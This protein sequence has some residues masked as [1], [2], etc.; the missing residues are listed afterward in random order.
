MDQLVN[1]VRRL[2]VLEATATEI[3]AATKNP[4][5]AISCDI[6]SPEA[7]AEALD[8]VGQFLADFPVYGKK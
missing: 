2:P 5:L 4:V 3:S 8:K 1:L 6:R 7:I